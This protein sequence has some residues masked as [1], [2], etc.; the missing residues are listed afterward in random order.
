[1]SMIKPKKPGT[2]T[3]LYRQI[4]GAKLFIDNN[5]LNDIDI[6]GIATEAC[7]S[8][9]HF[10]RLFKKIYRVTPH[11]Y[12]TILKIGKAKELL[13]NNVSITDTCYSLGFDSISSFI[14]LFRRY[15][16][17]S[18]SAYATMAK[19][20]RDALTRAPLDHVPLYYKTYLGWDK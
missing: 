8:K 4:V 9:F 20:Y 19:K 1:M 7:F 17:M 14:K 5:Y 11:K 12:V 18:P 13:R 15:E 16:K 2:K 6:S 10:L 3:Y